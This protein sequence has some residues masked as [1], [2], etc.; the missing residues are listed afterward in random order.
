MIQFYCDDAL[1]YDPRIPDYAVADSKA[2][3]EV[4][5]TGSL[6]F[7]IAPT[8][9]LYDRLIK[10]KS[11]ICVYQ[12]GEFLGAFRILNT[13]L[14]FN[15]IKAVSCEGELA[16]LLDS[17]QRATELH[18]ISVSDYFNLLIT[19]HN[20][21]VDSDKTFQVGAVTVTDPNDSLYRIHSYENTWE[22]IEDK[23]LDRL[24]GY[25]R[26]RRVNGVRTIDYVSDY[27]SVNTQVIQ[28][29]ENILDL[30]KE[31]RG[32]DVAT[33]LVPL[34]AADE[35]TDVR[36]TV[37]SVN[38]GLDYI[39]NADAIAAYGRIVKT[40]TWDD[41]TVA[42]NLLTK[43]YAR[44]AELCAPAVTLTMS[45]VDLH[46]LDVS[47]ERIKIGDSIRVV[48]EP[49]GLDEY[50]MVQ[51]LSL[52]FQHPENSTV[53][54]GTVLQ[55]LDTAINSGKQEPWED[56]LNAQSAMRQ[57]ISSVRTTVQECYSEI[58]KTAEEIKS[59]VSENYLSKFELE[60][61]QRDFQTSI[62]QSASEIRMDFTTITNEISDTVSSNQQLLEEYIR[63][64]GALIELGKVG[65]AFTAELSNEQLAFKEN[66]QTIAYISNQSLVITNAEIRSKLSLGT[67][68]RGWFDFIP[69]ATGNLSIQWRDPVS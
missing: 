13:D 46:L 3:L 17:I 9:P 54:L 14:D 43:G 56:I 31:I 69:R 32:E 25:I 34:G 28:F 23:L 33:V 40:E 42:S 61:I 64:R 44:L 59:S 18:G 30:T 38:D 1:L 45:A 41:V 47:V 48:S 24:G 57:S 5:K 39:E 7:R 49:H 26:C 10:L 12:D 6:S 68:E 37:A 2:E 52:D 63:F 51:K 36:L 35:E 65:S 16:Y 21:D 50:M 11:E 20:N 15:N 27:G 55:T 29:G 60:T 67:E 53:I 62:T 22:C 4:N 8:H 58:S 19:N 66:G